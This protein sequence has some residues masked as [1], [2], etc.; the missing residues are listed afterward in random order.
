[1]LSPAG[2]TKDWS[3]A[4]KRSILNSFCGIF[5]KIH[6]SWRSTGQRPLSVRPV[7]SS[8]SSTSTICAN[9]NTVILYVLQWDFGGCAWSTGWNLPSRLLWCFPQSRRDTSPS[10]RPSPGS[11]GQMGGATGHCFPDTQPPTA[12]VHSEWGHLSAG[13]NNKNK[14]HT[15]SVERNRAAR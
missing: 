8:S 4:A 7:L 14:K 11:L 12:P 15:H 5:P 2:S 13:Q 1:M 6:S 3:L 10:D 9:K